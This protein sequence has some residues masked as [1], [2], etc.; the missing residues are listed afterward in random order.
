MMDIVL[1]DGPLD[2]RAMAILG[3]GLP[4]IHDAG[5]P[6]TLVFLSADEQLQHTYERRAGDPDSPVEYHFTGSTKRCTNHN[7][8]IGQNS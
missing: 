1:V 8:T 3:A 6:V 5:L 7:R 2:G 4:L